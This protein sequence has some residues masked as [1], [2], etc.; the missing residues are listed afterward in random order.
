MENDGISRDQ[1]VHHRMHHSQSLSSVR[2]SRQGAFNNFM[3][4]APRLALSESW[5]RG[6]EKGTCPK[7]SK[8][9]MIINMT[10]TCSL[11][12]LHELISQ[13]SML[14]R[15]R[16]ILVQDVVKP[17]IRL[18]RCRRSDGCSP[19]WLTD[20]CSALPTPKPSANNV[21]Q[22]GRCHCQPSHELEPTRQ[23]LSCA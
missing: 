20:G 16:L 21:Q 19:W 8:L 15:D 11:F 3:F 12:Y 5:C 10:Y 18:E 22:D 7:A 1:R 13:R 6:K 17:T 14:Q 4:R 23:W 2:K 9:A